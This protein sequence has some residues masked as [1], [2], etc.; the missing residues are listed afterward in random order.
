MLEIL[1]LITRMNGW[2]LTISV[3]NVGTLTHCNNSLDFVKLNISE[4]VISVRPFLSYNGPR[5]W[6][7]CHTDSFLFFSFNHGP[8]RYKHV[9]K[10]EDV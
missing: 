6:H 7:L 8:N 9:A 3:I 5:R 2:K 1:V 4:S 10:G